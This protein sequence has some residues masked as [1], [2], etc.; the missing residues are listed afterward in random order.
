MSKV[1]SSLEDI[2]NT[3]DTEIK[4]R[5][6]HI[7]KSTFSVKYQALSECLE[8]IE[9]YNEQEIREC[10]K[11]ASKIEI[12]FKI[13][14]EKEKSDLYQ[15][16]DNLY[17]GFPE[18]TNLGENEKFNTGLNTCLNTFQRNISKIFVNIEKTRPK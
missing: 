15:C 3:V 9:K 4:S 10:S 2:I 16:I 11:K 8:K 5:Y 18:K 1:Y 17:T 13:P 14:L 6:E 7:F 12:D